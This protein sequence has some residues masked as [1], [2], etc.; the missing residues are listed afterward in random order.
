MAALRIVVERLDRF[1]RDPESAAHGSIGVLSEFAAVPPGDAT[2]EQ[3]SE[4]TG[5]AFRLLLKGGPHRMCST[6]VRWVARIEEVWIE[7]RTVAPALVLEYLAQVVAERLDVDRRNARSPLQHGH[8]L[9]V[10]PRSYIRTGLDAAINTSI[11]IE[12]FTR[13][14]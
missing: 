4:R 14:R 12:A 7:R 9:H 11:A 1:R 5:H 2:V 13:I 8:L 10:Q 6:E 3:P